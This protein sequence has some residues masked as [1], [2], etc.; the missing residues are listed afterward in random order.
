MWKSLAFCVRT[1]LNMIFFLPSNM[2]MECA[3]NYFM[4]P[5]HKHLKLKVS[6]KRH[7]H[8]LGVKFQ[9]HTRCISTQ[10]R[11]HHA[12]TLAMSFCGDTHSHRSWSAWNTE[13]CGSAMTV[14]TRKWQRTSTG[15]GQSANKGAHPP[16]M[17]HTHALLSS[18][19]L[20]DTWWRR[21][22]RRHHDSKSALNSSDAF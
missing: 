17:A 1:I 12:Y 15:R 5:Q 14:A 9:V 18:L 19:G 6:K 10:N 16:Q 7:T 13:L 2:T 11:P 8:T 22:R 3:H 20:N 21:R 4:E